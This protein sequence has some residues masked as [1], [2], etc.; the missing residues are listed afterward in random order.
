MNFG[1]HPA[2]VVVAGL[3][4]DRLAAAGA[5]L[6]DPVSI[7]PMPTYDEGGNDELTVLLHEFKHDL[8]QYLAKRPEGTPRTMNEVI[9]FNV[10]NADTELEWFGQEFLEQAAVLPGLDDP[11]YIAARQNSLKT[12][13]DDGLDQVLRTHEL[14][15]LVAPAFPPAIMADLVNGDAEIGGDATTAPAIAGYPILSVPMGL[16]HGLPVGLAV[17]GPPNSEPT[18]LRVAQAAEQ[19]TDFPSL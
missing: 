9:A 19:R 16:V 5:I 12:A 17:F 3:A 8:N 2:S 18:M 13:R 1:N 15:A 6:V 14:D 11:A 10:E 4:I 7:V